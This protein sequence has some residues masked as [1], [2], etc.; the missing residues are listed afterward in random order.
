MAEALTESPRRTQS[1][2][3]HID[4]DQ[5]SLLVAWLRYPGRWHEGTLVSAMRERECFRD[6]SPED[7]AEVLDTLDARV[8]GL[9]AT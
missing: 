8:R 5:L 4:T 3:H 1:G 6:V 9:A 2:V 7:A